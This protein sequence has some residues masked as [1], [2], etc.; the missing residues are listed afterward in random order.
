MCYHIESVQKQFI[1]F[2]YI[3]SIS[4]LSFVDFIRKTTIAKM[5]KNIL[6]ILTLVLISDLYAQT[7]VPEL[8]EV[9]R[10]DVVPRVDII[11]P[12]YSLNQILDPANAWS[13]VEF[14][15]DFIF[16]NGNII[17][18]VTNV[19]FRLRGNTSRNAQKKSFKI[20]FNTN[21]AGRKFQGLEKMNLNGEHNDP[22]I[23]RSVLSWNLLRKIGIPAPRA[24]HVE[25]YINDNYFGLYA[26]V[27]HIDENFVKN[28]FGNNDGNLYKCYWGVDFNYISNY[29]NAYKFE[30]NGRRVYELKTNEDIDDYADLAQ[31]IR[32]LNNTPLA[33]LPCE[34]EKVFNVES[35]LKVIA[36]DVLTANWDGPIWN[37]NNC[38]IYKNT[39]TGKFEFIPYDLDNTYG[40]SWFSWIDWGN[41]NI[42]QWSQNDRPIYQ[43]LMAVPEYR[44]RFSFYLNQIIQEYWTPTVQ[45]PEVDQVKAL[46]DASV[47]DDNYRSLD[48]GF[49]MQDYHNSFVQPIGMHLT[50]GIK[51]YIVAREQSALNQLNLNDIT[52][53]LS[54]FQNSVSI[55]EQTI[56]VSIRVLDNQNNLTV[57]AW[58]SESG[59]SY[60]AITLF[61]DGHG[62]DEQANDGIY[63]GIY[64]VV[65]AAGEVSYYLEATDNQSH[66]ARFPRCEDMQLNYNPPVPN[67]V[68]NEILASNE[69]ANTDN[70]EEYEDWIELYNAGDVPV[71][72]EG[73]FLS[74]N[75]NWPDKWP[76]PNQTLAPDDYL[77]I[78]ADEDGS[79]GDTHANFKLSRT[80]ETVGIYSSSLNGFAPI[81]VLTY[82]EQT[83]DV[84]YG[85]IPNGTGNFERLDFISPNQNNE[86]PVGNVLTGQIK[87]HPN[88]FAA[89]CTISH[90][91]EQPHLRIFDALGQLVFTAENIDTDFQWRG[92]NN[93]GIP[94]HN[95]VY[96]IGLYELS[97]NGWTKL[98]SIQIL[99]WR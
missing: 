99:L 84:S 71:N 60:N 79:Q 62:S 53:Y 88:P 43:R 58:F 18:T 57:K 12:T 20:S 78:W 47:I 23:A 97:V 24:N 68:I 49:D 9:Y 85:R 75:P 35:Y 95:G 73:L 16:D 4:T 41:H 5:K 8:G 64:N 66:T 7:P 89:S 54:D 19:G 36:F 30:D 31:F 1:K 50:Y 52:P 83:T 42:Y 27:E 98:S 34:L 14:L 25:L 59:A 76:L 55:T 10:N 15:A 29:G 72:L 81:D 11:I 48:Y 33:D 61:D 2:I 82:P 94:L 46:I 67:L 92:V 86:N 87:I 40:V 21:A 13:D 96:F 44:D 69:F 80:G 63:S 74:D 77:I 93:D 56:S 3:P 37:K 90:A 28:R 32:I 38:Y 65:Q 70:Y 17:D 91:F 26:N 22:S 45:F 39:A 51:D 6:L